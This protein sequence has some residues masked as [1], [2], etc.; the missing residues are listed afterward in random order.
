MHLRVRSIRWSGQPTEL[1][2]PFHEVD[3]LLVVVQLATGGGQLIDLGPAAARDPRL[4][5]A[6]V[7]LV[8]VVGVLVLLRAEHQRDGHHRVEVRN[9]ALLELLLW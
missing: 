2:R 8:L 3:A 6:L 7:V 5:A 9:V 4:V 1:G